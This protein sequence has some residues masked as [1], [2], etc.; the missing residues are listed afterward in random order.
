[1]VLSRTGGYRTRDP[2]LACGNIR[3]E[4]L[5]LKRY[6][7]SDPQLSLRFAERSTKTRVVIGSCE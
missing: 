7:E 3:V 5:Q 2:R 1:M 4:A 6:E